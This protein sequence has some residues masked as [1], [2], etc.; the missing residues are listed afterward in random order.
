MDD[1]QKRKGPINLFITERDGAHHLRSISF[2]GHS[3]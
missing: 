1:G 2:R 3:A